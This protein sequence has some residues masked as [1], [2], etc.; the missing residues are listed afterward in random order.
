MAVLFLIIFFREAYYT[1]Q[2]DSFDVTLIFIFYLIFPSDIDECLAD[3]SPCDAS[4]VCTNTDGSYTCACND[5]F[6][7]NGTYCQGNQPFVSS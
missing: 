6:A 5:G 1:G 3:A 7:G 2:L 4:A